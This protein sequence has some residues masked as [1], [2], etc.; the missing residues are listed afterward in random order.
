EYC[1][2]GLHHYCK[3]AFTT[4]GDGPVDVRPGSFA[5]YTKTIESSLFH[6]PAD[7]SFNAACL[8]EPLSGAW[9]GVV[10]Y[11]EITVG[12]DVVVIGVGSIGLL[13]MMVAKA[14]GAARLIAIDASDYACKQALALGATHAI[15]P[16][17]EDALKRVYEIIPNGPDLIVEAA[18]PIE[19]V[20]LMVALRRRGTRWNVFGITTPETFELE[21]GP[22]HFL[23]GRMDAS[24][25]TNP[26]AMTKSIR[27]MESGLVNTERIISHCFP[28]EEMRHA[29]EVMG[30]PDRNKIVINPNP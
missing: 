4:G 26:L 24:C 18:G 12:D 19:A 10:Q 6:K 28:L 27:L 29:V 9:K 30:T 20:K 17:H 7:L 1:R 23:E 3:Q 11:S 8:T 14:A 5:Q 16:K 21:G 15:N 2:S 25:G 13:C 22:T